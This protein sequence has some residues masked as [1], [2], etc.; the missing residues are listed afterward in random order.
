MNFKVLFTA[1]CI[2]SLLPLVH[3]DIGPKSQGCY[4]FINLNEFSETS[5]MIGS[6]YAGD[7]VSLLPA[8][9]GTYSG[10][11]ICEYSASFRRGEKLYA[12][13]A[14]ISEE[15]SSVSR[16]GALPKTAPNC[17]K[18]AVSDWIPVKGSYLV[19]LKIEKIDF[20]TH[21]MTISAVNEKF[22]ISDFLRLVFG[23][24]IFFVLVAGVILFFAFV[25]FL[26]FYYIRK[27][28]GH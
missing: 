15:L 7:N 16:I 2:L 18:W 24:P 19:S 3:A 20:D 1:V 23:D 8:V 27:K 21:H 5:F 10:G 28:W 26:I 11:Q 6:Y 17:T 9:A 25:L 13:D 12:G 22:E 14:C 4:E